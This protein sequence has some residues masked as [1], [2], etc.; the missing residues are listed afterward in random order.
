MLFGIML[1]RAS[2]T[3][4]NAL[5]AARCAREKRLFNCLTEP[6]DPIEDRNRP[7]AKLA[8]ASR[9]QAHRY[10]AAAVGRAAITSRGG[11]RSVFSSV[12]GFR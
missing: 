10:Q 5:A 6:F 1:Y 8:R 3:R 7:R 11:L 12:G 2:K 9:D 4:V